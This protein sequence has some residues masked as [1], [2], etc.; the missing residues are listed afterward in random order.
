MVYIDSRTLG[1]PGA[2][3]NALV[4]HEFQHMVHWHADNSEDSWVNEGL[5]RWPRKRCG[6]G[7]GW[8]SCS[9]A[10]RTRS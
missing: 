5:S 1:S 10:R 8:L 4:A 3:Y 2:G 7:H 6:G 9:W